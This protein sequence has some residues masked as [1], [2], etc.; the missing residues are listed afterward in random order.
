MIRVVSATDLKVEWVDRGRMDTH[1]YLAGCDLRDAD[2]AQL[3]RIEPSEPGEHNGFHRI[4]HIGVP[5]RGRVSRRA[6]TAALSVSPPEST[7]SSGH[8]AN[9]REDSDTAVA[10]RHKTPGHGR[11]GNV[12]VQALR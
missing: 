3:E 9:I 1:P 5:H 10:R 2:L 11:H 7:H 4:C 8:D 12:P 6:R